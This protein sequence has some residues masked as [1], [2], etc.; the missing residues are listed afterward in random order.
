M[1]NSN[2][3]RLAVER[4]NGLRALTRF[5]IVDR[6]DPATCR[7]RVVLQPSANGTTPMTGYLPV[8]T[9]W[10]GNGW[11][12]VAPVQ[13]GDQVLVVFAQDHADSG[14]IVGRLFDAKHVPPVRADGE[15]IQ[16]GELV[17]VH[18]SGSR[19][20]LT[21]DGKVLV[22]GDAE[23]DLTA[24]TVTITASTIN[25]RGNVAVTGNLTATGGVTAGQGG[26]DQVTVQH[27]VHP[28]NGAP[29]SAGS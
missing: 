18:R 22:S 23:L 15:P 12:A 28:S 27:H 4:L 26:S 19:L 10:L 17:L 14:V 13:Q 2:A 11:G 16:A 25:L 7:A 21:N 8:L 20:E 3:V 6:Y 5:G 1:S 24:P 29:P 9:Q